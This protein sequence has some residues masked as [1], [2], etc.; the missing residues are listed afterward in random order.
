MYRRS[1]TAVTVVETTTF[2]RDASRVL[3]VSE[4][5]ALIEYIAFNP[6]AGAVMRGTGG[7]RKLRWAAKGKGK[8]G[9]A[10]VVYYYLDERAPVF[11]MALFTKGEKDNLT[12]AERN[13]LAGIVKEI[14]EGYGPAP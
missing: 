14:V 4:C 6:E 5:E 2:G 13:V 1:S 9:G 8:S 10:R 12:P 11:L 7:V 3:S